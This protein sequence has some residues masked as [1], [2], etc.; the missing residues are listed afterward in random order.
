MRVF[1][2]LVFVKLFVIFL[3]VVRVSPSLLSICRPNMR[4]HL[5]SL[6]GSDK[7]LF[8]IRPAC[9]WGEETGLDVVNPVGVF[10]DEAKIELSLVRLS[11]EICE[12]AYR[13]SSVEKKLVE[14]YLISPPVKYYPSRDICL[15]FDNYLCGYVCWSVS[16]LVLFQL[17]DHFYC[18]YNWVKKCLFGYLSSL[19]MFLVD[20]FIDFFFRSIFQMYWK[21]TSYFWIGFAFLLHCVRIRWFFDFLIRIHYCLKLSFTHC[22]TSVFDSSFSRILS[23]WFLF[24]IS[25]INLIPICGN[26]FLSIIFAFWLSTRM[27][28]ADCIVLDFVFLFG[29]VSNVFGRIFCRAYDITFPVSCGRLLLAHCFLCCACAIRSSAESATTSLCILLI[30]VTASASRVKVM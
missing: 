8:E 6:W 9:L 18:Y 26:R 24:G 5:C 11:N 13:I 28:V 3:Y 21:L 22:L 19:T 14:F 7:L 30:C 17:F 12:Y 25:W 1:L 20:Y 16:K 15:A 2:C 27:N 29:T 23:F 4:T 10:S